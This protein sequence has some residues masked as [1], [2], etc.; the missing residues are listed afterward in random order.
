M[1]ARTKTTE[2][3]KRI[4]SLIAYGAGCGVGA[5]TG[6]FAPFVAV[7]VAASVL[8]Y[9]EHEDRDKPFLDVL[10]DGS[11]IKDHIQITPE[12]AARIADIK[13]PEL[14]IRTGRRV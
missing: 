3:Q 9:F 2:K 7:G 13:L 4:R 14:P 12:S 1:A 5:L 8:A 10:D 11:H 6:P